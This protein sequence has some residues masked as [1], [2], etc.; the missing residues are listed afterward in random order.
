MKVDISVLEEMKNMEERQ[1]DVY[2]KELPE[3]L[4]K[5]EIKETLINKIMKNLNENT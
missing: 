2:I 1:V 5:G 3:L 4:K